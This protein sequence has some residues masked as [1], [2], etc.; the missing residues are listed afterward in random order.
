M[1]EYN[2]A[3]ELETKK[4]S[5]G[6]PNKT[7][8]PDEIA[9]LF[10]SHAEPQAAAEADEETAKT[11]EMAEVAA[12]EPVTEAVPEPDTAI[13]RESAVEPAV[14]QPE[15]QE[16]LE[17]EEMDPSPPDESPSPTN[18]F[19]EGVQG[20]G[21][22]ADAVPDQAVKKEKV[23]VI[24]LLVGKLKS[25][26]PKKKTP[27]AAEDTA[28]A[29]A[30]KADI[31]EKTNFIDAIKKSLSKKQPSGSDAGKK[32]KKAKTARSKENASDNPAEPEATKESP[33]SE[34]P[35]KK[36]GLKT[37]LAIMG[38]LLLMTG[39]FASGFLVRDYNLLLGH[40]P[41]KAKAEINAKA[42]EKAKKAADEK[43]AEEL[44]QIS[45]KDYTSSMYLD[46]LILKG[47][48]EKTKT[49]KLKKI[50]DVSKLTEFPNLRK[51][52]FDGM[53]GDEDLS[54]IQKL[55]GLEEIS[56]ENSV[57]RNQ[58]KNGSFDSVTYLEIFD[59][60][61]EVSSQFANFN[62]L[63]ELYGY[64]TKFPSATGN[65]ELT[66]YLPAAQSITLSNCGNYEELA[67]A[68]SLNHL[69]SLNISGK[70]L[71]RNMSY[72]ENPHIEILNVDVSLVENPEQLQRL[73]D[74]QSLKSVTIQARGTVFSSSQL[75]SVK[76]SIMMRH[77]EATV[78]IST[79]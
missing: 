59:S 62:G 73:A 25:I 66:A 72:T 44:A 12:P 11:V 1:D 6:D 67:G 61:V 20:E 52:K 37:A 10:A 77:P 75:G 23:N 57:I 8:S 65:L 46:S 60:T 42:A 9:Q 7:L 55:S 31:K 4:D 2:Q 69:T 74:M 39:S 49:I 17:D 78:K 13:V 79:Y 71:I 29:G 16:T 50:D 64:A 34:K 40:D 19:E 27:P 45:P 70:T 32:T 36:S 30:G 63:T 43:R 48:A 53:I 56:I 28:D 18:P 33:K 47:K 35:Q 68:K 3:D 41:A 51:I 76:E 24:S 21:M 54:V 22:A 58:F 15:L 38:V 26:F 14:L 5:S